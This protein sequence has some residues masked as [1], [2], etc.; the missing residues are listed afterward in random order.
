[1]N[2]GF[3]WDSVSGRPVTNVGPQGLFQWGEGLEVFSPENVCNSEAFLVR[4]PRF[5]VD[6]FNVSIALE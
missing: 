3:R 5:S 6:K 2:Q 4:F 1:M